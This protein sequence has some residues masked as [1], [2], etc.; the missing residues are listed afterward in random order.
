MAEET[1]SQDRPVDH[2]WQNM[3]VAATIMLAPGGF[4]LG[5]VL[6]ARSMRKRRTQSP[7]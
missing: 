4:I 3:A 7:D 6:L 2:R 1:T 5:G